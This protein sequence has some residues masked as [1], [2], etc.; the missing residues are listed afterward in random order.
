M[1]SAAM[2]PVRTGSSPFGVVAAGEGDV[3]INVDEG[4][5]NDVYAK[6][7]GFAGD[8]FA[9]LLGVFDAEGSGEAHGG[10]LSH[11]GI[12]SKDAGRSIGHADGR[13]AE[14]WHSSQVAGLALVGRGI[15]GG[16]ANESH[17]FIHGHLAQQFVNAGDTGDYRDGRILSEGWY[18]KGWGESEC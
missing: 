13:Y 3:A 8:D 7:L 16:A 17:L 11:R 5:K 2:M 9:V 1:K 12:A 15:F 14:A 10:G 4:L 18:S 6:R